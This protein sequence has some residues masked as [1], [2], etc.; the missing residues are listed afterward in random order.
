MKATVD[1]LVTSDS[2]PRS[3]AFGD[4][5]K[6]NKLDLVVANNG[7]D[8]IGILLNDYNG[9][10]TNQITYSTGTDSSPYSVVVNNFNKD[11]FLDIAVA[12]YGN[13]NI[14]IFLG[15]A[16]G[17][18]ANYTTISTDNS[19]PFFI[20]SQD[21]NNDNKS[22]LVLINY[23]TNIIS[24]HLGLG[25]G[26]FANK[27]T[28]FMGY[29]T[30][31][32]SLVIADFDHDKI[33]DLA[34]ANFGTNNIAIL[35][36][37]GNGSFTIPIIYTTN[38]R[39]HPYSI[40]AG[41]FNNDGE[42]DLVVANY[43]TNNIGIFFGFDN[44]TFNAV[45]IFLLQN[46]SRPQYL[47]IGDLNNDNQTD[48]V[49]I[50]ST[51]GYV[52]ILLGFGNGTF[53]NLTTY[54]TA[55]ESFPIAA[56]V[57][58]FNNDNLSDIAVINYET[59]NVLILMEYSIVFA[60]TQTRYSVGRNSHPLS[61]AVSDFNGD[62]FLDIVVTKLTSDSIGVLL[63][64]GNG[65]FE[66]EITL[67]LANGSAP[68]CVCTGDFNNDNHTDLA[69]ANYEAHTVDL[70]LG[71]GNG[72]F[73]D[74]ITYSTGFQ[75]F[76]IFV[77][78]GYFNNDRALDIAV[79]N[80]R[81]DNIAIF[82]GYGNGSFGRVVTYS[83]GTYSDPRAIVVGDFNNDTRQ[84]LAIAN[85]ETNNVGIL[86]GN[87]DGT[88]QI[89]ITYSTGF[90]SHP[91]SIIAGDLN[92]DHWLDIIVADST[93]D[94]IIILLGTR[95]G[96][97]A[98]PI[99]YTDPTFSNPSGLVLGDINYDNKLDIVVT[100]FG[101]DN[102][103]IILGSGNG[104]F[105][106]GRSYPLLPGSG[107][108][109]IVIGD[110]NNN[111]RWDMVV[112]ES[113]LG[114]V[115]LLVRYIAADFETTTTYSTGSGPHPHSVAVGDINDDNNLDFVVANSGIDTVGIYFGYGNGSFAPQTSYSLPSGSYPQHV[116]V[117]DITEDNQLDVVIA[118][119]N[120]DSIDVLPGYGN[121][122]FDNT[123]VYSTEQGSQP[124]WVATGDFNN[125]DRWD[126]VVADQGRD[127]IGILFGYD[128]AKFKNQQTY[129]NKYSQRPSSIIARDLNNDN[130]I[131]IAT[132]FAVNDSVGILYG[133]GNGLFGDLIMYSVGNNSYPYE[134]VGVDVNNDHLLDIVV[135]NSGSS[136]LGVLLGQGNDS[137]AP[138]LIFS[139]GNN[140][141]PYGAASGDFNNDKQMDIVVAN[142]RSNS[143]GV[144]LGYGN[145]SF[146]PV[147]IYSTEDG[148]RPQAV[149]V[150]DFNNDNI[151]DIAVANYRQDNVGVFIGKGDGTF[152]SQIKYATGYLS[153]PTFIIVDDFNNDNHLDIAVSNKNN[154][155]IGIFY[156]YGNGTFP[157]VQLYA[158]GSGTSPNCIR[159]GR[160]NNDTRMDIAVASP[161]T[162]N[163]IILYGLGDE[164]FLLGPSF[165]TGTKS[166]PI[167]IAVGDFNGDNNLDIT[168]ANYLANNVGVHISYGKQEL[169]GLTTYS[170]GPG[171]SPYSVAVN[172][173]NNDNKSDI[174][175][176][177]YGTNNIGIFHG[178]SNGIFA[179]MEIYQMEDNARPTAVAV[180][181][182]NNDN[183]TDI[184]VVNSEANNIYIYLG[185]GNG[186]FYIITIYSTGFRSRPYG[187]SIGDVNN[188]HILDIVAVTSGTSQVLVFQGSGNG[189][190]KAEK[191]FILGYNFNP[192]AVAVADFNK[193]GWLDVAVA[194]YGGD[195]VEILLQTC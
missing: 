15:K 109:G 134:I 191:T 135:A 45:K 21:L 116:V 138:V 129:S 167:S 153:M 14:A 107:P 41:D 156:G 180:A 54:I 30:I 117:V 126:F 168:T 102:V 44:G 174:V 105:T 35:Y 130:Y 17:T 169:G 27:I 175:V 106:L 104:S 166:G 29:D 81:T 76:P 70:L 64:Y 185:Y 12:N 98:Q 72:K 49:I 181:D 103:G 123:V 155:N 127:N 99:S 164:T 61:V 75:S 11:N 56:V 93:S 159:S 71:Y 48:I 23:G 143:I 176:A 137:F 5:N 25:D 148:S 59:N 145:G 144:L 182:L 128:Y 42:L 149:A 165:T 146:A 73:T 158:T 161:G 184:V 125:D 157:S 173:F 28:Y 10:F 110:F 91:D 55:S 83:S 26:T 6:D 40:T 122:N 37:Y 94:N 189:T 22:D 96:T 58:D 50:D 150:G 18:F 108:K 62:Q 172:D 20:S 33:F 46:Q 53:S 136:T 195:Y 151:M 100:N 52:H 119:S 85:S 39:S 171:S 178:D 38:H 190:F 87:G 115:N 36:G 118:N 121:G 124:Y 141:R 114:S 9:T 101:T 57:N 132:A 188:D 160:F 74:M 8:N 82:L 179:S 139:T 34:V 63:G 13:H 47:T 193:D 77:T 152:Q 140:S 194:N 113:G 133:C 112:A 43:G 142:Y 16:N 170:T 79:A 120:G 19:R 66:T 90:Y 3:L 131:D 147:V 111:T 88:F 187:V 183:H 192:Y 67:A 24:I 86:F 78:V 97:F 60:V 95:N 32:Y 2:N 1:A 163:I 92:N 31:P 186:S 69:V 65:S 68:Y 4:F 51:N 89:I 7:R 84:D 162:N 177:N 80:F 154:D